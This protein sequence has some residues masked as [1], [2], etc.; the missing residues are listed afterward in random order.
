[1][2]FD[3]EGLLSLTSR[4]F[5]DKIRRAI[6]QQN[7]IR[8]VMAYRVGVDRHG[9]TEEEA[10]ENP[11]EDSP[12]VV[13]DFLAGWQG[14]PSALWTYWFDTHSKKY[15]HQVVNHEK[16]E[17]FNAL[18]A[19]AETLPELGLYTFPSNYQVIMPFSTAHISPATND[20]L[21]DAAQSI[22]EGKEEEERFPVIVYKKWAKGWFVHVSDIDLAQT[23]VPE[24]LQRLLT[25]ANDR[26]CE[27]I[28][29]DTDE[30][31]NKELPF[32]FW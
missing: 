21:A 16:V 3:Y 23:T 18:A 28:M 30:P 29:I 27:W 4:E 22:A 15:D 24:D 10:R 31:I 5:A 17:R 25:Y 7:Q 2:I 11:E 9:V 14:V 12:I 6:E 13:V 26:S 32:G 1:M 8:E 19:G 20:W